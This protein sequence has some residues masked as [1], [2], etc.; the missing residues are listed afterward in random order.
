MGT[1]IRQGSPSDAAAITELTR[2]LG[3]NGD[4]GEMAA[5]LA[6]LALHPDQLVIVAEIDS[7][8]VVGWLQAQAA[9][10]VESGYRVE[11]LGLVVSEQ[12]RR[13]GLG[14]LLV[15]HSEGWAMARGAKVMVVRSNVRRM[16]SHEFYPA[17]G[18]KLAKTQKVYRKEFAMAV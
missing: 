5:R 17:L 9:E 4:A 12:H 13:L 3:Y 15:Q 16:E 8:A 2:E 6:R 11:I 1:T 7:H 10:V 14:R 18:F